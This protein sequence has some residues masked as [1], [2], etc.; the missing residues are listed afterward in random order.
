M[1]QPITL[2]LW[3]YILGVTVAFFVGTHHPSVDTQ[4]DLFRRQELALEKRIITL[5]SR[6][7]ML[8][9][10]L[11]KAHEKAAPRP[12]AQCPAGK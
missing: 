8:T 7:R 11:F 6:D 10:E 3:S 9:E 2:P 4:H 5:E 1:P 12:S